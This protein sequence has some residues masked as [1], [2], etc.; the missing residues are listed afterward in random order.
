MSDLHSKAGIASR[1]QRRHSLTDF[2]ESVSTPNTMPPHKNLIRS[3]T[4][5]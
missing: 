3:S 4:G 5:T 1:D 2:T